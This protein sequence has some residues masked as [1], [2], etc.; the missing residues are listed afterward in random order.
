MDDRTYPS[1]FAIGD[2]LVSADI[3]TEYFACDYPVCKGACCIIGDSGAPLDES[4]P[5]KIEEEFPGFSPLM[6][7]EGREVIDRTGF[8]EIDVTGEMV[9]PLK[10]HGGECAYCM[11]DEDD[12]CLCAM[13]RSYCHRLERG[14][15]VSGVFKKPLSCELYPIRVST[16]KDGT[17][18]L[19]LHRWDI[20]RDAFIR[21]RKEG[22]KVYQFL[23]APII[24]AW[25]DD[26]YRALEAAEGYFDSESR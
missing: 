18:A 25:G 2:I 19:N 4:E 21:G 10:G 26:F 14:E 23:K 15:D 11:Y 16:F 24:R 3:I 20:C 22:I 8:F 1:F 13:E 6:S 17:V 9:T 12:N 5:E 7:Q